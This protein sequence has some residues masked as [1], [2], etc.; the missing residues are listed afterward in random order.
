MKLGHLHEA[1]YSG[2]PT[3]YIVVVTMGDETLYGS[4][5]D[6]QARISEKATVFSNRD[7]AVYCGMDIVD[8][9]ADMAEESMMDSEYDEFEVWTSTSVG[10]KFEDVESVDIYKNSKNDS[11]WFADIEI[12][13]V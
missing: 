3:G 13:K 10:G 6:G 1:R 5:E 4:K 7:Q 8:R 9:V 11:D 12:K 2:T